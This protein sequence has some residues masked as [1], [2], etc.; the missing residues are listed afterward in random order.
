MFITLKSIII[1]SQ[2]LIDFYLQN[3]TGFDIE[4]QIKEN[5]VRQLHHFPSGTSSK[6]IVHYAQMIESGR[7]CAFDYGDDGNLEY[8]QQTEPPAVNLTNVTPP[9]ALYLSKVEFTCPLT[10]P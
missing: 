2:N 7:F 10:R 9:I 6:T 1:F 8:Y 4:Q 5:L 3:S